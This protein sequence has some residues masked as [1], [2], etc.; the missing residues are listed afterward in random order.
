MSDGIQY[1]SSSLKLS[2]GD[3][4]VVFSSSGI[5]GSNIEANLALVR[6]NLN[7]LTTSTTL[8][9]EM[10]KILI[11]NINQNIIISFPDALTNKNKKYIIRYVDSY[12][13]S[14]NS[15]PVYYTVTI[16]RSE[17]AYDMP[18][19]TTLI[20]VSDGLTWSLYWRKKYF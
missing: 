1:V 19:G 10:S 17:S 16:N 8:S 9:S 12:Q 20:A 5:S 14:G 2:C 6:N 13:V 18:V 3:N 4:Q 7:I 15:V 11:K